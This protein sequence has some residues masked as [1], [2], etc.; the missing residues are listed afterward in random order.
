MDLTQ[1]CVLT[2]EMSKLVAETMR[3]SLF[4]YAF[5]SDKVPSLNLHF[6]CYD[7]LETQSLV[8]KKMMDEGNMLPLCEELEL[9]VSGENFQNV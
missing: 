6:F 9:L 7:Y 5:D 1:K 4:D 3:E 2:D 8:D